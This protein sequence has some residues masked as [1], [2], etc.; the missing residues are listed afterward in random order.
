MED[1]QA[2][3]DSEQKAAELLKLTM[4]S[5]KMCKLLGKGAFGTVLLCEVRSA[6]ITPSSKTYN[7]EVYG[8]VMNTGTRHFAIKVCA[9]HVLPS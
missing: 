8:M 2:S 4:D 3:G 1:G 6:V 9:I 5:F 7:D